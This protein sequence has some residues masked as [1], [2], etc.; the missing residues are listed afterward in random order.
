L[1]LKAI[2]AICKA[3]SDENR[4]RIL[5]IVG[6][7]SLPVSRIVERTGLSQPLVSHH[8]RELRLCG[9]LLVERSGP[10]VYHRIADAEVLSMLGNLD[11]LASTLKARQAEEVP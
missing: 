5:T 9:L 11:L 8:L 7:E 2:A 1:T 3:L 6:R 10:F 4:L